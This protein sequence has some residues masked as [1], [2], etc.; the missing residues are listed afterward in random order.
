MAR[1][2]PDNSGFGSSAEWRCFFW[3]RLLANRRAERAVLS[4][5]PRPHSRRMGV[6]GVGQ[7]R[8]FPLALFARCVVAAGITLPLFLFYT[9]AFT[10]NPVF[11]AWSAQN[12]LASPP[13]L[14]YLLAYLPL[15]LLALFGARRAWAHSPSSAFRWLGADCADFGL[16]AFQCAAADERGGDRP[17]GDSRGGGAAQS[18]GTRRSRRRARR[19][20]RRDAAD[21]RLF[22]VGR[23]SGSGDPGATAVSPRCRDRCVQLAE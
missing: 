3:R 5:D 21:E 16:S 10:V 12:L 22:A 6:G 18:G 13:P 19:V 23:L 15:G 17:V 20:G 14:Q 2:A 4:G 7:G 8:R 1:R 11:A 9:I